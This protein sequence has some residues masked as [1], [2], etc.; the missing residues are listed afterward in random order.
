MTPNTLR[1][2]T[3][4]L[5]F[6]SAA[7]AIALPF[8]S[9]TALT[10][11]IGAVAIAAGIAQLLRLGQAADTRSRIFRVLAGA[12]YLVG[13]LWILVHPVESEISLT[14]FTGLL[15]VGEG[16]MELAGAAASS[17]PARGLV[18]A[19]GLITAL[20]GGLL[21]AEWPSDSLWAVGTL[22]GV[23]L[24]FSAVNLLSAPAP[25]A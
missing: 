14:L 1:W 8:I 9:A 19:D 15:L 3:A 20:L 18:I 4:V 12:L 21:V 23:S 16:V 17:A 10:I 2:I 25:Q 7:A 11:A 24:F 22:F 6:I 5:L 13:G